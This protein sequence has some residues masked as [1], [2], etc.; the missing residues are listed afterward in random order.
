MHCDWEIKL[1]LK[2]AERKDCPE[3][4]LPRYGAI[5]AEGLSR[6]WEDRFFKEADAWCEA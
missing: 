3:A 6:G 2:S 4:P 5:E 1:R